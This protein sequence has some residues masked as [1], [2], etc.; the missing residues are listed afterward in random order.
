MTLSELELWMEAKRDKDKLEWR[1]TAWL[2]ARMMNVWRAKNSPIITE[3]KLLGSEFFDDEEHQFETKEDFEKHKAELM[4]GARW[5]QSVL[6]QLRAGKKKGVVKDLGFVLK[7]FRDME[8]RK[9]N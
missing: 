9:N 3:R 5:H 4:K 2:A 8:R 7:E 1:R 6:K